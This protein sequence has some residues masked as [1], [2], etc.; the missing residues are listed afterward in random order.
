MRPGYS[1]ITPAVVHRLARS[2]LERTLGFRPDKPSVT[3]NQL[4]DLILLVAATARTL[5]A[6]ATRYFPFS[7]ETARRALR[8]ELPKLDVLTARLVDALHAV[9]AFTRRDR[10]RLWTA[11]IDLHYVPYYGSRAADRVVG[12][13]KKHGTTFFHGY[14]TCALIHRRRRY[15]VGLLS[16]EKGLKP[17]EQVKALLEQVASRGLKLGGVVL[18]A[19]FDSGETLLLLQEQKVS[20]TVPL[21]RKGSGTNRRNECYSKPSGTLAT[22]EWTT[23]KSR[24]SV[25]TRVLVWQRKGEAHSRVYAFSGWG[26]TA[27]VSEATRAW[28]GRRRYRER[29]GIETSYRQKNQARGWTTSTSAEYRLLLEGLALVLRQVWVRL[30]QRIAR[31][32]G[33]AAKAWVSELPLVEMLDW[34]ADRIRSRD[35]RTRQITLPGKPLAN[36]S[37]A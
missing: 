22:M 34:L 5:F 10:L 4:L 1:T 12:G 15:T 36:T 27:A 14:A 19:G 32:R 30:T 29:F 20:Y 8:D 37:K 25:T 7:H 11:A 23:E 31:A 6:I 18:D 2:V 13:P 28:V 3:P 33:L 24:K 17:H 26:R 9:A 16:V 35:P 21:R